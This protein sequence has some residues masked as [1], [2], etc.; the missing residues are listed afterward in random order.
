MNKEII[1]EFEKRFPNKSDP[2]RGIFF[3]G[4]TM[5]DVV[6]FIDNLLKAQKQELAEKIEGFEKK[7][8]ESQGYFIRQAYFRELWEALEDINQLLK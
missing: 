1:K 8:K 3:T 5:D 2:E 4:Y 6:P 7:L